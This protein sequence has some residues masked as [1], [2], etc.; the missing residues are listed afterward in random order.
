MC[1]DCNRDR[2]AIHDETRTKPKRL[3][4][5]ACLIFFFPFFYEH[6][7]KLSSEDKQSAQSARAVG[8]IHAQF[9]RPF[10]WT[11]RANANV[12]SAHTTRATAMYADVVP[13]TRTRSPTCNDGGL[14]PRRIFARLLRNA[15]S[16]RV[17]TR[18]HNIPRDRLPLCLRF[19]VLRNAIKIS[20]LT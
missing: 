17:S 19:P 14:S 13:Y 6:V 1:R 9:R 10:A 8:Y 12:C 16:C 2:R 20:A 11:R 5:R 15:I 7:T 4:R 18:R 3:R